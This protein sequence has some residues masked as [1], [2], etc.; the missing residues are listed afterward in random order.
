M[1]P[2]CLDSASL[3]IHKLTVVIPVIIQGSVKALITTVLICC[4]K[5]LVTVI[6]HSIKNRD[7]DITW[8]FVH[9]SQQCL[10]FMLSWFV[11]LGP[12]HSAGRL[13]NVTCCCSALCYPST[14][15]FSGSLYVLVLDKCIQRLLLHQVSTQRP[16]LWSRYHIP[17]PWP[18]RY[19]LHCD[20]SYI[21]HWV[22][23]VY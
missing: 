12:S 2:I 20:V 11:I 16:V 4:T 10:V 1:L 3:S 9:R 17:C 6:S 21:A 18:W 14:W 23:H 7:V 15:N 19:T 22:C 8:V 13:L 5:S